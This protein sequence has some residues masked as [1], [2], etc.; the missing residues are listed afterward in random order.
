MRARRAGMTTAELAA[1][2]V[3]GAI[4]AGGAVYVVPRTLDAASGT[5]ETPE[6]LAI[7]PDGD[8]GDALTELREFVKAGGAFVNADDRAALLWFRDERDRGIMNADELVLL[9]Y[10]GSMGAFTV[11]WPD[12]L[13]PDEGSPR[14]QPDTVL[15]P[16]FASELA[17]RP[18][19]STDVLAG[20]FEDV[21]IETVRERPGQTTLIFRFNWANPS[22]D[23]ETGP[24]GF[25]VDLPDASGDGRSTRPGEYE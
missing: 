14:V 20:G 1:T 19:V 25:S 22:V 11:T 3:A 18:D 16:G 10:H 17:Y 12:D 21:R 24:I 6:P 4:V 23:A 13:P 9:A 8:R 15:G 5:A 2:C 7:P